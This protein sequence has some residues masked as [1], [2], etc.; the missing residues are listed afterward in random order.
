M[1]QILQNTS[2]SQEMRNKM[3]RLKV[4]YLTVPSFFDLEISLIRELS[5][6]CEVKVLVIVS[7]ESQRSSAFVLERL[8]E[9]SDIFSWSSY[10]CLQKYSNLINQ[11]Q[12]FIANNPDNSLKSG[13]LLSRKIS[14]WIKD[15]DLVHCTTD[16]KTMLFCLPYILLKN[17]TLY[18]VHDPIPHNSISLFRKCYNIL[19]YR[20]FKNLLFLSRSYGSLIENNFKR[21][22]VFY[23]KLGT[24]DFLCSFDTERLIKDD[25]ILFFGRIDKYKGVDV[26]IQAY[27]NSS[28]P[29]KGI[30][31][32]IAGK[33]QI[34]EFSAVD[35]NVIIIN[36]YIDNSELASLIHYSSF[37]VLPYRTV[38]QSGVLKS[39]Y[40]F[41]KPVLATRIGDFLTEIH[42]GVDG[43][44]V[45]PSD[46]LDLSNG[47]E[48][49]IN[50]NLNS[51]SKNVH[52]KYSATSE[53]GWRQIARRLCFDVYEVIAR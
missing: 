27:L 38:T 41:D 14:K 10:E 39:A 32:V 1:H 33:G 44:L 21:Y 47:L 15:A 37:V 2:K 52:N 25:Y 30:K 20:C 8:K 23:S 11:D 24:Y 7:P 42:D 34:E 19:G 43:I 53:D 6:F 18:T 31:L 51:F 4:L 9:K 35:S 16:C 50:S 46:V 48:R 29:G 17:K 49:M 13:F 40:A 5:L 3:N 36:R 45:N 26:L 12:W 22:N 28:L